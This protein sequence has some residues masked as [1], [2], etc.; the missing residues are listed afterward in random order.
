MS[1]Y[2]KKGRPLQVS[3]NKVWSCSGKF[4]GRIKNDKIYGPDGKYVGTIVEKRLVYRSTD[5]TIVKS[6]FRVAN[7]PGFMKPNCAVSPVWGDEPNIPD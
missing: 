3:E 1:L 7:R 5:G 4:V 6:P 2:T